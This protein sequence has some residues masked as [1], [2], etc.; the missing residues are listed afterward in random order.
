MV[1][2]KLRLHFMKDGCWVRPWNGGGNN[3]FFL[4][5]EKHAFSILV[6]YFQIQEPCFLF[7]AL[8]RVLARS[9][10]GSDW[11]LVTGC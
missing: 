2:V 8:V 5:L 7:S 3:S 11:C 1:V 9:G 10:N 4:C 6:S